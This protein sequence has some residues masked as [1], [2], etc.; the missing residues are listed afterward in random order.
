MVD[1]VCPWASG[2]ALG[3]GSVINFMI[4]IRG[5]SEDY[6][7]WEELGA[8]GW[9]YKD[10]LPFFK[11]IEN[12]MIPEYVNNGYHSTEGNV[13]VTMNS[14]QSLLSEK[15]LE[16]CAQ[17][18]YKRIDYNGATQEGYS[19]VQNNIFNGRRVSASKAW[20]LPIIDERPNLH[21]TLNS[22]ATKI[23]LDG[24]TAVGV[25]FEKDGQRYTVK[26]N[27]EVVLSAGALRSPQL[28]MVS[29][30][31]P[32]KHLKSLKIPVIADL[33]VGENLMDHVTVGG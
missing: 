10:V 11:D 29:G 4:Y 22:F 1:K 6:D 7:R 33:P 23:I 26:A 17:K 15:F 30:I 19:H 20:I 32:R 31:G 8:T 16:A 9:S 27:Q 14:F 12:F 13:P 25:M 24:K 5:N 28:L 21:I 2:K 3:G 18:G